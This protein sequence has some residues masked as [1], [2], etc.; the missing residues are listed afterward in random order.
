MHPQ[1]RPVL[2][3]TDNHRLVHLVPQRYDMILISRDNSIFI[4]HNLIQHII[5]EIIRRP[6]QIH[7]FEN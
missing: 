2:R 3:L 1:Q 6:I 7:N 5:L 4:K